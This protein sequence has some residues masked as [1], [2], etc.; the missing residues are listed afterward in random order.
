MG[1][2]LLDFDTLLAPIPGDNPGGESLPFGIRQELDE[3]RK[4]INPELFDADDPLRPDEPKPADWRGII[5]ISQDTL[6][7]TSKDLL[8]AAR[9]LEALVREHGFAGLRAGLELQRRMMTECWDRIFPSI[10]DGDLEVR[11]APFNW[12]DDPDRGARFPTTMR[13]APIVKHD[14]TAFSWLTWRQMQDGKSELKG[15]H[16]DK[17]IEAT[18]YGQCKEL[19]DNMTGSLAELNQLCTALQD[20]L[21]EFAPGMTEVRRA[22][23]ECL[24]LGQQV[25]KKKPAPLGETSA[26]EPA[27][28]EAAPADE[29]AAPGAPARQDGAPAKR[30]LSRDDV[31]RQLNDAAKLLE[32]L[33]P[34]SPIPYLIQKAI[35]L[36][37]MPFP[38]LIKALIRDENTIKELNRELGIKDGEEPPAE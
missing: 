22:L 35:K 19:V 10:E 2:P 6:T 26:E 31:Y 21:G 34:H 17:A 37:S 30:M 4:E 20:R 28:G 38:Q 13:S 16:F 18:S 32:R 1:S 29:A 3:A 8:V 23:D 14:D 33:E 36:G 12:L 9:L 11:S 7:K 15:E 5:R 25:L 27:D 24:V